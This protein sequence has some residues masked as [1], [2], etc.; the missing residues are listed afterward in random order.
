MTVTLTDARGNARTAMTTSLGY[1]EFRN[2]PTGE[3][4]TIEARA[5]RYKFGQ[6][7]QVA[8]ISGD[9]SEIIFTADGL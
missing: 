4:Y 2:V 1:Y 8:N 3:A 5:K 7:I 6:P 9:I